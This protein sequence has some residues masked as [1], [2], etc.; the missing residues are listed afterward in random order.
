METDGYL[1]PL[2]EAETGQSDVG[3]FYSKNVEI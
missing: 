2:F 1:I 3:L